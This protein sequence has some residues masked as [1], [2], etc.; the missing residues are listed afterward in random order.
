MQPHAL[1][2]DDDD[3]DDEDDD[4]DDDDENDEDDDDDDVVLLRRRFREGRERLNTSGATE[5]PQDIQA[6]EE[7]R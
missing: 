4:D 3:D 5:S 7:V 6:A 1:Q 2:P